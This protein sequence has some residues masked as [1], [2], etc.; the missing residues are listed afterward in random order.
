MEPGEDRN[1][2]PRP[3]RPSPGRNRSGARRRKGGRRSAPQSTSVACVAPSRGR[4]FGALAGEEEGGPA[5]VPPSSRSGGR[6]ASGSRPGGCRRRRS[7][8]G[9][10]LPETTHFSGSWRP[11]R[12][13]RRSSST[14]ASRKRHSARHGV[15]LP[16]ERLPDVRRSGTGSSAA[17]TSSVAPAA[18]DRPK[19]SGAKRRGASTSRPG[20]DAERSVGRGIHRQ[21]DR[22]P[23]TGGPGRRPAERALVR[24]SETGGSNRARPPPT[25]GTGCRPVRRPVHAISPLTGCAAPSVAKL[26]GDVEIESE[27]GRTNGREQPGVARARR[28]GRRGLPPGGVRRT[29]TVSGSSS[30]PGRLRSSRGPRRATRGARSRIG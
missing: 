28:P 16:R 15:R 19:T 8:P 13:V 12:P 30:G 23:R 3:R 26:R 2:R 5:R 11:R 29:E 24:E 1:S 17:P 25:T 7:R 20:G 14:T 21:P 18:T 6:R 27:A 10:N 22:L 4:S 9:K